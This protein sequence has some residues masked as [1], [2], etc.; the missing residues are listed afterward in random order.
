MQMVVKVEK[1]IA[2][3]YL[4]PVIRFYL[5]EKHFRLKKLT[6][7]EIFADKITMR[8]KIYS[9]SDFNCIPDPAS[10]IFSKVDI[11]IPVLLFSIL[12]I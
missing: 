5:K 4:L 6:V 9:I 10:M 2:N 8:D 11:S 3:D 1:V 12:E 7:F